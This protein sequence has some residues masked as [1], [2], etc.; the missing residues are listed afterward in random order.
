MKQT[1]RIVLEGDEAEKAYKRLLGSNTY[2]SCI[3]TQKVHRKRQS[4]FKKYIVRVGYVYNSNFSI[5][6]TVLY[7][8]IEDSNGFESRYWFE[9][10]FEEEQKIPIVKLT[11]YLV[12][13]QPVYVA[14][15]PDDLNHII[16]DY[17]AI[18]THKDPGEPIKTIVI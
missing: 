13:E 17:L 10:I 16:Q 9:S 4:E 14:L 15:L 1:E 3:V 8:L 2:W 6:Q 11:Y 5:V 18:I 7:R 12:P